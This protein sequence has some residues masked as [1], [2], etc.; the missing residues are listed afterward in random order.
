M[1]IRYRNHYRVSPWICVRPR[2]DLIDNFQLI[3]GRALIHISETT[4]PDRIGV[5]ALCWW[6]VADTVPSWW[7]NTLPYV[8]VLLVL[9]FFSQRLRMPAANGQPY[10][11]G[12]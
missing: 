6:L 12:G 4:P 2:L 8:I 9:V 1:C 11:K 5:G 3:Q 7:S 10:R